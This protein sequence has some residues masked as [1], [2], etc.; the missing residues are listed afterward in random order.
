MV[1]RMWKCHANVLI[2]NCTGFHTPRHALHGQ[3]WVQYTPGRGT[4]SAARHVRLH[5]RSAPLCV[6]T[7]RHTVA[8]P[9]RPDPNALVHSSMGWWCTPQWDGGALCYPTVAPGRLPLP[10]DA[11]GLLTLSKGFGVPAPSLRHLGLGPKATAHAGS[12]A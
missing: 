1:G 3:A 6:Y 11:I 9:G 10:D 4:R 5:A 2:I 12:R 7:R 8:S